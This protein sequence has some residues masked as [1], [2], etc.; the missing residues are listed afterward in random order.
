MRT[1]PTQLNGKYTSIQAWESPTGASLCVYHRKAT[2]PVGVVH[3]NHGLAEHG[4]RYARFA[5]ALSK[6]GFHVYVHDHRGH[7]ATLAPDAQQGVFGGKD[8]FEKTLLDMKFVNEEIKNRHP[9][10]P[11]IMFGHSMGAML[12]YNYLLRWSD[13]VSA[14]AIW[15]TSVT[16]SAAVSFLRLYLSVERLMGGATKPSSVHKLTFASWNKAFAPNKTESDWLSKD[17]AEC[18]KYDADPDCGWNASVSMWQALTHGIL[19][20]AKDEGLEN[21]PSD[22][23]I[24][25]LGGDQDPSVEKGKSTLDLQNRLHSVGLENV[26]TVLRENGRHEA[27]NEPKQERDA[28]TQRF[29]DWALSTLN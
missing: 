3:I 22:M 25:I 1:T 23:P 2:K 26:T 21:I 5:Q 27:L 29:V 17:L 18:E 8:G 7:G 20:G 6:A 10:L 11:I 12:S 28:I 15:N 19:T 4:G 24:F 9:D 16:K 13:T 14:A